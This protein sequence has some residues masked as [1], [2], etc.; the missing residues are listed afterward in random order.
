MVYPRVLDLEYNLI[1]AGCADKNSTTLNPSS[2]VCK[3]KKADRKNSSWTISS[4]TTFTSFKL[5]VLPIVIYALIT[6]DSR[7]EWWTKQKKQ[8]LRI[9][10]CVHNNPDPNP[11]TGDWCLIPYSAHAG[12]IGADRSLLP[13]HNA[14][15]LWQIAGVFYMHYHTDKI[16]RRMAFDQQVNETGWNNI[17]THW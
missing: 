12:Y 1:T 13:G 11:Q 5:V 2:D 6:V 15:L 8:P 7:Y 10:G 3:M 4:C 14:L 16:T 17:V 9:G